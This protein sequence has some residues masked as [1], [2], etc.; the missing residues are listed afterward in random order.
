MKTAFIPIAAALFAPAFSRETFAWDLTC[1]PARLLETATS[2]TQSVLWR[3][4]GKAPR[5]LLLRQQERIT[6]VLAD[7]PGRT[8]LS[9]EATLLYLEWDAAQSPAVFRVGA[10]LLCA[11]DDKNYQEVQ[12]P[13]VNYAAQLPTCHALPPLAFP[14]CPPPR[15]DVPNFLGSEIA[16]PSIRGNRRRCAAYLCQLAECNNLPLSVI[17]VSAGLVEKNLLQTYANLHTGGQLIMLT[18]SASVQQETDLR[19]RSERFSERWHHRVADLFQKF[20]CQ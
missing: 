15:A 18:L 8:Q 16:L 4:P 2:L 14:A 1:G 3:K 12:A 7:L 19:S 17:L 6:L 10:A 20:H 11:Y 5:F 13:F 9:D